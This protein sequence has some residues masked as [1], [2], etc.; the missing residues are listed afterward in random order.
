MGKRYPLTLR[1]KYVAGRAGLLYLSR[2]E[3]VP[4]QMEWRTVRVL[5]PPSRIRALLEYRTGDPRFARIYQIAK[6]SR[7][8]TFENMREICDWAR[9]A[10][11]AM[12]GHLGYDMR[13]V[14]EA[15]IDI[16]GKTDQEIEGLMLAEA[17]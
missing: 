3:R 12:R 13:L 6:E 16:E 5:R 14:A 8:K 15:Q 4:G 11:V 10:E 17:I 1:E 9:I 7:G 2:S